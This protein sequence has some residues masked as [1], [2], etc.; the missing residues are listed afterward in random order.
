MNKKA[1][2]F[3]LFRFCQIISVILLFQWKISFLLIMILVIGL[4]S[5][6]FKNIKELKILKPFGGY[7]NC[8]TLFRGILLIY[9]LQNP[10][11]LTDLAIAGIGL[12]ISAADFL[13]GYIAR[14]SNTIT[15]LGGYL[16]EEMDA[17]YFIVLGYI[18]FE[19]GLCGA[20]I[21]IPGIAKYVKDLM[22]SILPFWF[23]KPVKM[24]SAKWIAGISFLMYLTPFISASNIYPIFTIASVLALCISLL[25][26]VFI[27]FS[28]LSENK[29]F[30]S[31]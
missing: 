18:L 2:H 15:R 17:L 12:F 1:I 27:R 7:A 16:D 3:I 10:T 31:K 6:I 20:Y 13:D 26:E 24:P 8:L 30:I 28:G 22:V 23:Q 14:K 9:L 11:T 4:I 25:A 5:G 21:L 19:R 29:A